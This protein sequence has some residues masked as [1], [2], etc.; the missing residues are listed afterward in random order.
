MGGE[1]NNVRL[2]DAV[3]INPPVRLK[4]GVAYPFVEM[5]DVKPSE[6]SA[7]SKQDR[8]FTGGGSRF[9]AGDTLMARITPCLENEKTARFVSDND[10]TIAHGSTEFI[11]I[12]GRPGVSDTS[13]A[14]YLTRW[15]EVQ[16]FA[17]SQM[18]G[19]SGRQRVPT[20]ALSHLTV[21]LPP[22]PI[23]H[24]IADILG[25]LDDKIELNRRT[26]ETLE[27]MA[28]ALFK[29]WFVDFDPVLAKSMGR[30][31]DG[32]DAETANLFPSS[33][34]DSEIGRV[35]KGWTPRPLT[36]LIEVNP[37]RKLAKGAVAP[38]LDMAALST[39]SARTDAVIPRVFSSGSKFTNGD[40]L[41]ARITP[42]LE[43][44]KTGF[45]DGLAE[46][47]VGWGST[48]FIVLR[49]KPPISPPYAYFMARTEEFR[50]FAIANMT[51][52]SGRQRVVVDSLSHLLLPA[53][54]AAVAQAFGDFASAVLVQMKAS[55]AEIGTLLAIR[56]SLLPRL[57]SGELAVP[58]SKVA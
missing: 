17:I 23:Q 40:T 56:D 37:S 50:S 1:W 22:L 7:R 34:V 16:D 25:S 57:L 12:R 15:R 41:V 21:P 27:A 24:A 13:F 11:V 51:G 9:A 52:T 8:P 5:Q 42:C 18:T 54:P 55:D 19:T 53:P 43:N 10:E 36:D 26:N 35:P 3:W 47:Q 49:P 30:Q 58:P 20:E 31:P 2:S 48:E 29:S 38:Y 44:G 4:R 32:M 14:Y 28:K 33:F 46:G 39:R 6:R 45:V